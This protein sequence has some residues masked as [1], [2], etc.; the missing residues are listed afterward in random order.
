[1]R[2]TGTDE[3]FED[4]LAAMISARDDGLVKSIGLSNVTLAHLRPPCGSRRWPACKT[5]LT[6]RTACR[7]R[8]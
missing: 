2:D 7:R 3:F 6:S 5:P 8:F 4:Q 1:M